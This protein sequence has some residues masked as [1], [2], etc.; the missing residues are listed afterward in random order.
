MLGMNKFLYL[1][2][3]KF[4][5]HFFVDV[6]KV[7]LPEVPP[8]YFGSKTTIRSVISSTPTPKK[9]EW[10]KSKDKSCFHSTGNGKD[11]KS[12]L[13]LHKTTFA[14]KLYYRLVVWNCIGES[15]SNTVHLTVTGSMILI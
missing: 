11:I 8:V 14:D 5:L 3:Q 4:S 9:I 7:E 12:S 13:V 1:K 10:Q 6:P 15:I 2:S